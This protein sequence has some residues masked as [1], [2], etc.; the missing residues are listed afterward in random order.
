MREMYDVYLMGVKKINLPLF[1]AELAKAG[2]TRR[3][4]AEELCM[5]YSTLLRKI[6]NN[7]FTLSE[8]EEIIRLLGIADPGGIFFEEKDT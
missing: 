6:K 7:S 2:Y 8:S 1:R 3:R 4:L 5:A